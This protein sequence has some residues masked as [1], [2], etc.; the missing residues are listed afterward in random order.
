MPRIKPGYLG[1]VPATTFGAGSADVIAVDRMKYQ[2]GLLKTK[3]QSHAG[4]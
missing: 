2:P 1:E 4:V 3:T